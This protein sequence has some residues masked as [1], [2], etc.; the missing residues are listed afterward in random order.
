MQPS[1]GFPLFFCWIL[2]RAR[3]YVN[4]QYKNQPDLPWGKSAIRHLMSPEIEFSVV[5]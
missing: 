4:G 5:I 1:S 3:N 2:N